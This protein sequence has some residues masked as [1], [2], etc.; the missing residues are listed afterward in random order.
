MW[1]AAGGAATAAARLVRA[2]RPP[3]WLGEL[4]LG[5]IAAVILGVTATAL[6][7]GGWREPDWRAGLFALFGAAAVLAMARLLRMRR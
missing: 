5:L 2:G 4:A 3:R 1:L 6:D 7:F